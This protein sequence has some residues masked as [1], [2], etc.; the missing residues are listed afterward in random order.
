[1]TALLGAGLLA[2]SAKADENDVENGVIDVS[3]GELNTTLE[4]RIETAPL[5]DV[6]V[7][8]LQRVR[9]NYG[10]ETT[11]VSAIAVRP[12]LGDHLDLSIGLSARSGFGPSPR[13]GITAPVYTRDFRALAEITFGGYVLGV[14]DDK[15]PFDIQIRAEIGYS[16]AIVARTHLDLRAEFLTSLGRDGHLFSE[17]RFRFGLGS[18]H[19]SSGVAVRMEA[20]G[21]EFYTR[22]SVGPYLAGRW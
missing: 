6:T 12:R 9:I 5:Q 18:R 4:A 16:P 15:E 1:M 21:N 10:E 8:A 19:V 20:E 14:F 13:I 17:Q 3:V 22:Y 7:E 2:S 11:Y